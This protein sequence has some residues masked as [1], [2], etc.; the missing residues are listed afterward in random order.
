[1]QFSFQTAAKNRTART[2]MLRTPHGTIRTPNFIPV[3]TQASVK[4]IAQDDL[5]TIGIDAVLANTYHLMLRPGEKLIKHLGGLHSFMGWRKP[6][7]TDSGGFQ[8]FSLGENGANLRSIDEEK[9]TFRSHIDHSLHTLTPERS[10]QIQH[11]LGADIIFTLDECIPFSAPKAQA[12][13]AME[14]THRWAL[15]C[16]A[17]HKKNRTQAK[18]QA[19]YGIVQGGQFTGLRKQSAQFIAAQEFDGIGLGGFFGGEQ[20]QAAL[21]TSMKHLPENK[22]RHLLGIGSIADIFTAVEAGID[23]FDC[24]TPTRLARVGYIFIN[25]ESGG[26]PTNKFRYR[27]TNTHFREDKKPLAKGC[28]CYTCQNFSR[29][30]LHHLFK[31][32]ELL[33]YRLATI[34]N[35]QVMNGLMAEMRSAIK[36]KKW[37][38]L[39]RRWIK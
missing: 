33:S 11:D 39:K 12:G 37:E 13:S 32:N 26:N 36:E 28:S 35:L 8:V 24:V 7:F 16:L 34:H 21:L 2:G 9:V 18:K 17:E 25:P 5:N 31:A 23:T 19:L 38:E 14:R 29:A 15:R 20:E 6:L 22:P 27:I 4:A 30:Y 3:A 1:M 10:I